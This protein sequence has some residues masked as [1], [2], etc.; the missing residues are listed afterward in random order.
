VNPAG[1]EKQANSGAGLPARGK[2]HGPLGDNAPRAALFPTCRHQSRRGASAETRYNPKHFTAEPAK[3]A[4]AHQVSTAWGQRLGQNV[5]VCPTS[6]LPAVTSDM[7]DFFAG[8]AS[9]AVQMHCLG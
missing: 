3:I 1:D 9:L 6:F 5:P 2:I 4:K 7:R 8:L